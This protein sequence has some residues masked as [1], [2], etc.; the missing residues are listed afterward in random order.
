M[1]DIPSVANSFAEVLDGRHAALLSQHGVNLE[2]VIAA[3]G[4]TR[5]ELLARVAESPEMALVRE[6]VLGG[7]RARIANNY[8]RHPLPSDPV[9][10]EHLRVLPHVDVLTADRQT[11][12]HVLEVVRKLGLRTVVL[13]SARL[14]EVAA[15]LRDL[16]AGRRPRQT[17]A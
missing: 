10:L 8:T 3:V 1:A 5:E 6:G 2:Q 9:D 13:R 12:S 7:V 11:F 17:V 15:T 16:A 14:G 4:V